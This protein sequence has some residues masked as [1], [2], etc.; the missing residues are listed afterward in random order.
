[1][2]YNQTELHSFT[3]KLYKYLD[4]D[5]RIEFKKLRLN[6]GFIVLNDKDPK[7]TSH[8]VLDHRDRLIATLI[9]EV[10]HYIYPT[11]CEGFILEHERALINQLSDRQIRNIIKRFAEVI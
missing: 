1:M 8:M 6:R 2:M 10:L 9:H 4:S 5:H 11:A 3:R 7:D